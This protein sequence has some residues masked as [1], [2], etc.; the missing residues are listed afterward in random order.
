MRVASNPAGLEGSP[1]VRLPLVAGEGVISLDDS[2]WPLVVG[3]CPASMSD[4]SVAPLSAFFERV[5]ARKERFCTI[6]DSR[7]LET[8]PSA[9]WRQD[10]TAWASDPIIEAQTKRYNV[11][12]A[13]VISSAIARGVFVALGWLRKP[14]SPVNAF[15][16]IGEAAAWCVEHLSQ[17]KVPLSPKARALCDSLLHE[18]VTGRGPTSPLAR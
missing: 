10:V 17:A 13:V 15:G 6:I 3:I 18:G 7:P 8:M 9:K 14:A 12:T 2:A 4:A 11:A 5:H 16:S 1:G